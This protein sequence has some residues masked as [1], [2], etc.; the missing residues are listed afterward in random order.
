MPSIR[1][2]VP[3]TATYRVDQYCAELSG[4]RALTVSASKRVA[5]RSHVWSTPLARAAA[6][7]ARPTRTAT[8]T[9]A[10][11]N[12]RRRG[13]AAAVRTWCIDGTDVID[14]G[15][16]SERTITRARPP[17][18]ARCPT[19]EASAATAAGAG[20]RTPAPTRTAGARRRLRPRRRGLHACGRS[21]RGAQRR[22]LTGIRRFS[23]VQVPVRPR[24]EH[25]CADEVSDQRER[26]V[27]E[28][29]GPRDAGG[30][31][32]EDGRR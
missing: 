2:R 13:N 26:P 1:I 30:A 6:G 31:V 12:A 5:V 4:K 8:H 3:G 14:I 10:R 21:Q 23:P 15:G 16:A 29:V 25:T 11:N 7:A 18:A 19:A 32:R 24:D 20:G 22:R 9:T 28:C 17:R 27:A